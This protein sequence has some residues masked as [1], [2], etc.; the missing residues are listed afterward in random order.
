MSHSDANE[1]VKKLG[2]ISISKASLPKEMIE[3]I[4]P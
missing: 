1:L 2:S 4:N 3:K